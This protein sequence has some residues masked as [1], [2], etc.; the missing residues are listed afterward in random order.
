M[1]LKDEFVSIQ[2]SLLHR[3]SLPKHDIVIKDLI[4]EEARLDTLRATT[5]KCRIAICYKI[6][7]IAYSE[8]NIL[9]KYT[10]YSFIAIR[11]I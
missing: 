8:D 6:L 4:S 5:R 11:G 3:N 1:T 10:C 9:A 2:S 7:A